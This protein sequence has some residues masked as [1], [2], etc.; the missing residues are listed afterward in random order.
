MMEPEDFVRMFQ[1]DKNYKQPKERKTDD[2]I[3]RFGTV[4][5]NYVSGNPSVIYDMDVATG[6][7]SKPLSYL[8]SYTPSANDRVMII[9]GV[10]VGKIL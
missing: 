2:V 10:I 4:D 5:Y 3:V 8:D 7:L 6:D 1:P 9:K